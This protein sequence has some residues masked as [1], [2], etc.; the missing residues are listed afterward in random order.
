MNGPLGDP[1]LY[2]ELMFERRALLFDIGNVTIVPARKLLRVSHV[3]ISHAHMDHFA[4][5]DH[6]LR[7]LLGRDKT[8]ALYGPA[9]FIDQLEHKVNA[10][11]WN[12]VHSYAGNLVLDV[13]EVHYDDMVHRSRFESRRGFRRQAMPTVRMEDDVLAYCGALRVRFRVLDHGPPVSA[14]PWKNRFTSTSGRQGWTSWAWK[15][16]RGCVI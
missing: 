12:V 10:Y 16:G 11:I 1:V 2:A 8:V 4:G 13:H 14:S 6:L 15:L 5:F 7:L 9:G 3:F